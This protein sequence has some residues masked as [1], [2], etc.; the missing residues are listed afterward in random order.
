MSDSFLVPFNR[1]EYEKNYTHSLLPGCGESVR[2][3]Y[4]ILN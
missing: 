4:L 3:I 2:L 1:V